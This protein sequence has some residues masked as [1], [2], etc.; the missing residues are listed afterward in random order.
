MKK[1]LIM[2][3]SGQDGAYL[4]ELLLGDPLYRDPHDELGLQDCLYLGNLNAKR[5]RGHAS[6]GAASWASARNTSARRRSRR[7]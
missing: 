6:A 3:V 5:D 4:A 1:A 7:C 2:G